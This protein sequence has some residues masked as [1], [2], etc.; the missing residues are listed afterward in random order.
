MSRSSTYGLLGLIPLFCLIL[1]CSGRVP[2]RLEESDGFRKSNSSILVSYVIYA[3]AP[4][5]SFY[6]NWHAKAPET[7]IFEQCI[8]NTDL[9]INRAVVEDSNVDF[10]FNLVGDTEPTALLSYAARTLSNV[11][12]TKTPTSDVD[13]TAHSSTLRK[14]I[15]TKD[16]FVFLNCETRGPYFP[17]TRTQ[18]K[19]SASPFSRK[20][21]NPNLRKSSTLVPQL[22]WLDLFLSKLSK[23]TRA[24]GSTISCEVSPHIQSSAIALDSVTARIALDLWTNNNANSNANNNGNTNG[25]SNGNGNSILFGNGNGKQDTITIT[26]TI[27]VSISVSITICIVICP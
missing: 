4:H 20:A 22:S 13:L 17:L 12:I 7:R 14:Y 10:V 15:E 27:T 2:L 9:F 1:V 16:Y 6:W 26:I 19:A 21:S 3:P 24:V 23:D 18:N 8:S 11:H 25:N 5:S